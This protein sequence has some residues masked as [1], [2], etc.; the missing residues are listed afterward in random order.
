[1]EDIIIRISGRPLKPWDYTPNPFSYTSLASLLSSTII[2]DQ[3][4]VNRKVDKYLRL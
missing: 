3:S 1:M 4:E 2:L